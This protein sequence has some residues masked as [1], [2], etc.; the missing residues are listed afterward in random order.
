MI[1]PPLHHQERS[2]VSFPL[3]TTEMKRGGGEHTTAAS[4]LRSQTSTVA[5][6]ELVRN[7]LFDL[8]GFILIEHTL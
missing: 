7:V 2:A 5:S 3:T 6:C 1:Q 8:S 4:D